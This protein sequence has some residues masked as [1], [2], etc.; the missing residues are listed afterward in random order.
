MGTSSGSRSEM[1]GLSNKYTNGDFDSLVNSKNGFFVSMCEDLPILQS[2]YP[3]FDIDEPLPGECIISVTYIEVALEKVKVNKAT[4][5]DNIP[6][7]VLNVFAPVT[8]NFNSSFMEG[9]YPKLWKSATFIPLSKKH[10]P[11]TVESDIRPISLTPILAKV[12]ELFMYYRKAFDLINHYILIH[13]LIKM[14]L[15]TH[16]VRWMAMF[17][18]DREQRVKIGDAVSRPGYPN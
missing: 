2:S 12:F 16:L 18:L 13:K 1:Q 3:I 4:E 7:L 14:E 5:P 10:P 8:A 11:D 9:V 17:L 15:P 6:P